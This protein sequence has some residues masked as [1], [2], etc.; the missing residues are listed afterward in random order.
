M[1]KIVIIE[2][3]EIKKT[4]EIEVVE[5]N[6]NQQENKARYKI[7]LYLVNIIVSILKFVKDLF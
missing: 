5:S 7:F 4:V 2:K 3:I 1:S 6:Q